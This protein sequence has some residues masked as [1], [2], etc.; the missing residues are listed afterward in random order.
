D[1]AAI[2]H[3]LD[4]WSKEAGLYLLPDPTE[5]DNAVLHVFTGEISVDWANSYLTVPL[6]EGTAVGPGEVATLYWRA[7]EIGIDNNWGIGMTDKEVVSEWSHYNVL[8]K[9]TET[10]SVAVHHRRTYYAATPPLKMDTGVWNHFWLV[11]DYDASTYNLW[12]KR[13]TDA[14]P[15]Q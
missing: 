2:Q 11:V 15:V 1:A 6:P 7:Y 9:V 5:E 12:V 8:I 13:P 10:S 4:T 3:H 14:A